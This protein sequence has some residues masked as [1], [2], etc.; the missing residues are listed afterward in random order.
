MTGMGEDW[1]VRGLFIINPKAGR[2]SSLRTWQRIAHR[3]AGDARYDAVIP[4]SYSE[5]R[6]VAAEAVADGVDRVIVVGGDG[7][8][9]AVAQELAYTDTAMGVVPAGTGNDFA[10]NIGL[11]REPE[12]AL[13]VA[14]GEQKR[15]IDLGQ[16]VGGEYFINAAG[17]GFDGE[18]AARAASFPKGLGGTLPYLASAVTTLARY[19]PIPM[20]V[21]V[22]GDSVTGRCAMVAIANGQNYGG[23][24]R[25]APMADPLDG[26]LDV[27]LASELGRLELLNLLRLVYTGGH[28]GHPKVR[29]LRGKHVHV[30]VSPQVRRHYDG[31][32]MSERAQEF[33]AAPQALAVVVPQD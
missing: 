25:I 19:Q 3:V 20:T 10:R 21:T 8:I 12:A 17:I 2:G 29:V 24:M 4:S 18:V 30:G 13:H 32:I 31:E 33:R 9:V 22:D 16:T 5:T 14:L 28:V 23:G 15:R 27:I 11:P 6:R 7:T 26:Q 1:D